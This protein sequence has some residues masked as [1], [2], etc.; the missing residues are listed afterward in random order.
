MAIPQNISTPEDG[1]AVVRVSD[2]ELVAPSVLHEVGAINLA[3]STGGLVR[4]GLQSYSFPKIT[5]EVEASAVPEQ[6]EYALQ[7]V[8]FDSESVSLVK[9]GLGLAWTDEF[10]RS[11]KSVSGVE[12]E[13]QA[14]VDRAFGKAWDSNI[15]GL[16]NGSPISS[17]FEF[18]FASSVTDEVE[19][20]DSGDGIRKAV[21]EAMG[22]VYEETGLAAN[23]ILLPAD[24]PQA[25]RDAR[26]TSTE[27]GGVTTTNA[28]LYAASADPL[29]GL[30]SAVSH[31]LARLGD[32]E[33]GSTTMIVGAFE[34]LRVLVHADLESE[35][36]RVA[37]M[38]GVSGFE[39][40][41]VF[42]KFRSYGN[43]YSTDPRAFRR[44]VIPSGS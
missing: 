29:Y 43:V 14:K 15:L 20:E 13:I 26:V 9:L 38:N 42:V 12:Q 3:R 37:A 11:V 5:G 36:S 31:N 39:T 25:L 32:Q 6:G 1:G 40:D 8:D 23:G 44:I 30:S 19:L 35:T 18:D 17:A 24:A 10:L 28:P 16:E 21:S 7:G 4:A 27:A 34:T 33:A 41:Q 22:Q 2:L